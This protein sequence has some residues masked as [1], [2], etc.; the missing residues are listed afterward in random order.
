MRF[1]I[2][3]EVRPTLEG[4]IIVEADNEKKAEL[5]VLKDEGVCFSYEDFDEVGIP[6]IKVLSIKKH[7]E[8]KQ[9]FRRI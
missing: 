4:N 6:D 9:K 1:I 7:P 2:G 8:R 3:V 5:L